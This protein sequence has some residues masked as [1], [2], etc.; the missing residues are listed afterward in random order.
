[1]PVAKD[2]F[3]FK[4][5]V[6]GRYPARLRENEPHITVNLLA[7]RDGHLIYSGTLT[8]SEAEFEALLGALR[9]SL[10]DA[11]EVE[12]STEPTPNGAGRP[13]LDVDARSSPL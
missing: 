10:K 1:M 13:P 11:V 8:F 6:L 12:D 4:F 2:N 7:G 9:F 3:R 5:V